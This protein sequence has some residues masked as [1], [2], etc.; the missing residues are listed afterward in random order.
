[1]RVKLCTRAQAQKKNCVTVTLCVHDFA[2]V[3]P[4]QIFFVKQDATEQLRLAISKKALRSK[5]ATMILANSKFA[6][7]QSYDDRKGL[8]II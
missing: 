3:R 2:F 5:G 6:L 4:P 7:I 8:F 1:M